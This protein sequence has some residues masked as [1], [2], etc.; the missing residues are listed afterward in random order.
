MK[1]PAL[2]QAP[3]VEAMARMPYHGLGDIEREALRARIAPRQRARDITRAAPGVENDS[4]LELHDIE[5]FKQPVGDGALQHRHFII[6]FRR[7]LEGRAQALFIK[8][9]PGIERA[10]RHGETP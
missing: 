3:P 2:K 1:R 4:G 9:W 6:G 5:A 8:L 7:A 10:V